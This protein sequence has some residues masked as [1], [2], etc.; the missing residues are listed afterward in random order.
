MTAGNLPGPGLTGPGSEGLN[1]QEKAL[2]TEVG[3][4]LFYPELGE[5]GSDAK[6]VCRRCEARVACL[7]YALQA[8]D[9]DGIFGGFT[10]RQRLKV[11]RDHAAGMPL[12]DIIAEDD[13]AFYARIEAREALGDEYERRQ[14]GERR[15]RRQK[16]EAL[17]KQ[18]PEGVAA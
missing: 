10:E 17:A 7:D 9:R 5:L 2:C 16:Q 12:E 4:D 15:R 18:P 8:R 3:G 6:T 14:A 1:W 11:A 13:A